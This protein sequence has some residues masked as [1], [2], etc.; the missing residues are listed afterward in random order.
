MGPAG[1]IASANRLLDETL[2]DA[3]LLDVNICGER[4]TPIAARLRGLGIPYALVT[5]YARLAFQEPELQV[6]KLA[7]PVSDVELTRTLRRLL[8][9][10]A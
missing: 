1:S 8:T 7:K 3:A 2:P 10:P 6:A 5:G 9:P 4:I